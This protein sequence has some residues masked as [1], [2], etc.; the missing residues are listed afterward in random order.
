MIQAAEGEKCL[1]VFRKYWKDLKAYMD[2][3]E[4]CVEYLGTFMS[5]IVA[6]RGL[7]AIPECRDN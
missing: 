6:D 7:G 3:D 5:K 1:D 4:E 2:Q